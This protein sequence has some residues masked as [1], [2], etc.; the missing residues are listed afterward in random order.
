VIRPDRRLRGLVVVCRK[1]LESADFD[2]S[3]RVGSRRVELCR[4]RLQASKQAA[5][6]ITQDTNDWAR[7]SWKKYNSELDPATIVGL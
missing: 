4:L 2:W 6:K 5:S 3:G 7:H 1:D